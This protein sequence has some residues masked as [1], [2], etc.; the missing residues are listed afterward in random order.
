MV[1][2]LSGCCCERYTPTLLCVDCGAALV[3]QQSTEAE[4]PPAET[5][6]A[7]RDSNRQQSVRVWPNR[8]YQIQVRVLVS[9][10]IDSNLKKNRLLYTQSSSG[11]RLGGEERETRGGREERH[12]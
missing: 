9:E 7:S 11:S 3:G 10:R 1:I 12:K 4:Q 5:A 8:I 6:T 2:L